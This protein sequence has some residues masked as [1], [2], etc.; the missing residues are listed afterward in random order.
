MIIFYVL[1]NVIDSTES[2]FKGLVQF[3]LDLHLFYLALTGIHVNRNSTL[4]TATTELLKKF[5]FT[6]APNY[7]PN[8]ILFFFHFCLIHVII[9][10][11]TFSI[12][13]IKNI[14]K[15]LKRIISRKGDIIYKLS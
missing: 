6:S 14:Y 12:S 7:F 4:V 1:N 9:K 13:G 3:Y 5:R 11:A 10:T 2:L 15:V 8:I